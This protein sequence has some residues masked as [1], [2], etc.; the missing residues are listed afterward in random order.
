MMVRVVAHIDTLDNLHK[1]LAGWEDAV[2]GDNGAEWLA[3]RLRAA[4]VASG[5]GDPIEDADVDADP[6]EE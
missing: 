2:A 4:G 6:V 5:P 1:I 3:S